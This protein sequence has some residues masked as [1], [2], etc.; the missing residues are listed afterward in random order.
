MEKKTDK[1]T[2]FEL[3]KYYF[4]AYKLYKLERKYTKHSA[5]TKKYDDKHKELNLALHAGFHTAKNF[6]KTI[7]NIDDSKIGKNR[8]RK[9]AGIAANT[10]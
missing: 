7:N 5:L 1:Y 6:T 8:L 9:L 3:L 10:K 4:T 2:R